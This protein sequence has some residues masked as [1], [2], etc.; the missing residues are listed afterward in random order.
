M[1]TTVQLESK[2]VRAIIARFFGVDEKKVIPNRYN[3]GIELPAE[4]VSMKLIEL[5][6]KTDNRE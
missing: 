4:Q 5:N 1:K 3:F 2:E 6:T